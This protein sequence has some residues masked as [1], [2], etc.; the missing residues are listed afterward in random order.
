MCSGWGS[1][2]ECEHGGCVMIIEF[3]KEVANKRAS[4]NSL[5]PPFQCAEHQKHHHFPYPCL[6]HRLS[7]NRVT[8]KN[9]WL[10]ETKLKD[11]TSRRCIWRSV[12]RMD[13]SLTDLQVHGE[14]HI[15]ILHL[16]SETEVSD[17]QELC[18]T[19]KP[20]ETNFSMIPTTLSD[21]SR[22]ALVAIEMI[23]LHEGDRR[24]GTYEGSWQTRSQSTARN[25]NAHW[26]M[27]KE[28]ADLI[29]YHGNI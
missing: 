6:K 4:S 23:D 12:M 24:R 15:G 16:S 14:W 17:C 1:M 22:V 28:F 26:P 20:W 8:S 27:S 5:Y 3:A 9:R 2:G 13:A 11:R 18:H 29:S 19:S 25:L 10:F 7:L 21:F